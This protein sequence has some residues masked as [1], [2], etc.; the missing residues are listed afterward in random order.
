MSS[1]QASGYHFGT[2][3]VSAQSTANSSAAEASDASTLFYNPA[4]LTK[5]DGNEVSASINLVAPNVK[6]HD[7]S[8]IYNGGTEVSRSARDGKITDDIV[9]APHLYG[10]Y[11][12]NKDLTAGLGVYVPFGSETEYDRDSVLRYNLNK[13]ELK[14]IA[15]EPVL[16]YKINEKHS[17][18]VGAIAQYSSAGLRKYADWGASVRP[19][20]DTSGLGVFDGHAEVKGK[21]W[22]F[23]YHL[24]WMWD[25]NENTRIGV[26]YRSHV[27]HNLK[28]N[29]DWAADGLVAKQIYAQTIGQTI[30]NGGTGYVPHEKAS[31]KITTPES[32]SIHGLHRISSKWNVFGDVTWTRHSRFNRAELKFE[33]A[34][35][36][37]SGQESNQTVILPN[38][39]NTYKVALGASYQVNDPL[40]VRFGVA[41]DQ[42]P[43]RKAQERL[44]TMPDSN[45]IW[46]SIGAKYDL[47]KKHIFNIAYSHI[48]IQDA[49][50]VVQAKTSNTNVNTVDSNVSSFAHY[51]SSANI[52]G[53]Q[54]NYKF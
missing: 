31:L 50:A 16:A 18:A 26:N 22:G 12:V 37:L 35:R 17:V 2:Q 14:T 23:G 4:G 9:F 28:G 6:Y 10:A 3:S 32:L 43:V 21:D 44:V 25:I 51:K 36:T 48:H 5:L 11:K 19:N 34:K 42:S 29:A 47:D 54:Y 40:Q 38:W 7:A 13:T 15:I 45:R 27:K 33:N 53:F 52:L 49:N 1:A 39:R 46:Y 20:V 8:A 24:A 41:Y 30:G